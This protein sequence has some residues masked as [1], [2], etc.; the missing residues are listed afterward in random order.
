MVA[1]ILAQQGGSNF[2]FIIS[3]VLMVAVFYFLLIRPQ[4]KR[5]RAQR[6]LLGSL[7]VGDEV[8][9]IGGIFGRILSMDDEMVSLDVGGGTHLRMLRQA[10]ARKYVEET[11]AEPQEGEASEES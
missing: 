4:Q 9:T 5:V 8:V 3:L 6:D 2:T 10:I 7:E 11:E 1:T